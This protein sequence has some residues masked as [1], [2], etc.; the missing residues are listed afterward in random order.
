MRHG[1]WLCLLLAGCIGSPLSRAERER[2]DAFDFYWQAL[3]NAYPLFGHQQVPWHELR[4]RYRAAVPYAQ[5]P[6]EFYHLL[7]GMFSEL[8]DVHVAFEA[9]RERWR[10]GDLLPTSLLDV[11]GF[12]LMPIEG[13][14]HVV[15][16][17]PGGAPQPPA[18]LPEAACHPELW[19]VEGSPVVVS[20]V[21]DLLRGP[22]DSPVELQ[23]RWRDGSLTRQVLR[24]PGTTST[25]R[26]GTSP[27]GH[28]DAPRRSWRQQPDRRFGWIEIHGFGD[29]LPIA[30]IVAAV[31]AA[32]AKG[33]LVL[34]LRRNLGGRWTVTRDLVE[35]FLPE[36][37]EL[38]FV[39]PE[40]D[41]SF[42]GLVTFEVF[43][44]STWLPRPPMFDRPLVVLTSSLTAS[45]AEHAA[46]LLQRHAGAIV[47]GERTVGAE[48]G[49][50]EFVGPD[51][52]RLQFGAQRI[53]DRTGV[54]LQT[55]GVVPDVAVRLTL[56]DVE[57]LGPD[58][59]V[60]DWEERLAAAAEAALAA[61]QRR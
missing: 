46:R 4:L 12:R 55:E 41:S 26:P 45:M 25:V 40:V 59:A 38:V 44:S 7:V 14:L 9:P 48:A 52:G 35:H 17:P 6:H 8:G 5:R 50:R 31:T 29:E 51:G 34:D 37:I 58:A 54:G 10:D 30:E 60:R 22:P 33:G 2:L 42:A 49:I 23:L 36:P 13:R 11:P 16:W 47:V 15:G 21:A 28:L 32:Q 18:G 61:R 1:T 56:A 43:A 57:A 19:R 53:V 24:R 39:Q 3:A 20:L 27:L